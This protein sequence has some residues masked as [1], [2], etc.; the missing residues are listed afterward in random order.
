ML[1]VK[2]YWWGGC[3]TLLSMLASCRNPHL[4]VYHEAIDRDFL[5]SSHVHTPDPQQLAPPQGTL[6]TV[7]WT[8]PGRLLDSPLQL[9]LDL[10]LHNYTKIEEQHPVTSSYGFIQ[11]P[12]ISAAYHAAGGAMSYRAWLEN[13]N[14]EIVAEW[15]HQLW[16]NLI[17]ITP[18][19]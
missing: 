4:L 15:K 19:G 10:L 17:T 12:L 9:H 8:V 18:E 7:E 5:A 13:Q 1:S 11:F 6:L 14:H 2:S 16:V 3:C